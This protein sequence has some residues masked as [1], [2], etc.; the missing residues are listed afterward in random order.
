MCYVR[1]SIGENI[2]ACNKVLQIYYITVNTVYINYL[3]NAF[4]VARLHRR[5]SLPLPQHASAVVCRHK[6]PP[7]LASTAAPCFCTP[8]P[9]HAFEKQ[10]GQADAPAEHYAV[11]T[12]RRWIRGVHWEHHQG[13]TDRRPG[14]ADEISND[15]G[16]GAP[17]YRFRACLMTQQ[18]H[19]LPPQKWRRI[20]T[21]L[22]QHVRAVLPMQRDASVA[23]H[24]SITAHT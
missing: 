21:R 13:G 19:Q 7:P 22:A 9:L 10:C 15:K 6:P 24:R 17:R 1:R 3:S 5:S 23:C 14:S 18:R 8:S 16:R 20:Q 11:V 12:A 2:L 4:P